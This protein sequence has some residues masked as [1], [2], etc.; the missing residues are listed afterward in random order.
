MA[1]IDGRSGHPVQQALRGRGLTLMYVVGKG[2]SYDGTM[3]V[4]CFDPS[5]LQ[6]VDAAM[7]SATPGGSTPY[8]KI[9][10]GFS[11]EEIMSY[12]NGEIKSL[13]KAKQQ[14]IAA[15]LIYA[16]VGYRGD[17]DVPYVLGYIKATS[18]VKGSSTEDSD[19]REEV[20]ELDKVRLCT[21]L[22][23]YSFLGER[24]EVLRSGKNT[25]KSV[26]AVRENGAIG[27]TASNNFFNHLMYP[28]IKNNKIT[29][30][31]E[32]LYTGVKIWQEDKAE[33]SDDGCPPSLNYVDFEDKNTRRVRTSELSSGYYRFAAGLDCN[34]WERALYGRRTVAYIARLAAQV[35]MLAGIVDAGLAHSF[36]N[37]HQINSWQA[38]V[39]HSKTGV[40]KNAIISKMN[41]ADG[42][43]YETQPKLDFWIRPGQNDLNA[44]VHGHQYRSLKTPSCDPTRIVPPLEE[45]LCCEYIRM[46]DFGGLYRFR[47]DD[48]SGGVAQAVAF[49]EHD[50]K[51]RYYTGQLNQKDDIVTKSATDGGFRPIS[52]KS[53]KTGSL[54]E[55]EM[56][57]SNVTGGPQ[58]V[59]MGREGVVR[60]FGPE[61]LYT[62]YDK[63]SEIEKEVA[64]DF[65]LANPEKY[66]KETKEVPD[67]FQIVEG[68]NAGAVANGAINGNQV[69]SQV[70]A[71]KNEND[72]LGGTL[73]YRHYAN[74]EGHHGDP[75]VSPQG[76]VF[77]GDQQQVW[78]FARGFNRSRDVSRVTGS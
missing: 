55:G 77:S 25:T 36:W 63:L 68:K 17:G 20:G 43:T 14:R 15:Q 72:R 30:K 57:S 47:G 56:L 61:F 1:T 24:D 6:T 23:N 60:S 75:S 40:V 18:D 69:V 35:R 28:A 51:N 52:S 21:G 64:R 39:V 29:I 59:C 70:E 38:A 26:F 73:G 2:V 11:Y 58:F 27:A 78:N 50:G 46:T 22:D 19:E 45:A 31:G 54:S 65:G 37:F 3:T 48:F 9:C 8:P 4:R 49:Y 53:R 67:W 5:T 33:C 44:S 41:E 66:F 76:S 34:T 32:P 74:V 7:V 42:L 16:V 71:V 13:S 62:D 12:L 10:I